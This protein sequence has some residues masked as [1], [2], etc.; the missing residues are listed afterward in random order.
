MTSTLTYILL[1]TGAQV[2][3]AHPVENWQSV[4]RS[5]FIGTRFMIST[6]NPIGLAPTVHYFMPLTRKSHMKFTGPTR[7]YLTFCKRKSTI[8]KF[9]YSSIIH[10]PWFSAPDAAH[11][12]QVHTAAIICVHA[13]LTIGP[14]RIQI[15]PTHPRA[16]QLPPLCVPTPTS[17]TQSRQVF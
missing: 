4:I 15:P 13:L 11:N 3:L 14:N 8:T 17:N 6:Q 1:G 10:N 9:S 2:L 16:L 7:S 5:T 12:S